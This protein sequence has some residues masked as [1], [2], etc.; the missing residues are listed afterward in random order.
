MP[1]GAHLST[2]PLRGAA[3]HDVLRALPC[4]RLVSLR[5]GRA[6]AIL[7]LNAGS[8][9]L[10]FWVFGRAEG[11]R[12]AACRGEVEGIGSQRA[13]RRRGRR[14]APLRRAD[15]GAGPRACLECGQA[16]FWTSGLARCGATARR[17][18]TASC[19]AADV[20]P[21]RCGSTPEILAELE[22]L[23]PLA[24]LHQPHNLAAVRA[25]GRRVPDLP[26]VACFDTAF[27]RTQP[28]VAQ[29][30]GLPRAL[31]DE[32][33]RRYG[34]HGLSYE[35]IASCCRSYPARRGGRLS[36]TSGMARACARSCGQSVATTMG[37]TARRR[38]ADGQ[39][40]RRARP[41][42]VLYLMRRNG[43]TAA[44]LERPDLPRSGLLGVSG[45]CERHAGSA[46]QRRPARGRGGRAFRLPDRARTRVAGGRARR[47]GRPRFTGGIGEHAPG[48]PREGLSCRGVAGRRPR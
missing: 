48:D 30:F 20:T 40:L 45:V 12:R 33:V 31:A 14:G 43:M 16:P 35:Y 46:G 8:S 29:R 3:P 22:R 23:L 11:T 36:R 37:F 1:Q 7:V 25:L 18:G 26:Q 15:P 19:T 27:H 5:S 2:A 38:L 44:R 41:R 42:R 39:A 13:V 10:K 17:G 24:P 34:F 32:G 28:D 21:R 47:P 4:P 6:D 9:S